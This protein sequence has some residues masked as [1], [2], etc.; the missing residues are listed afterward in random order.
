MLNPLLNFEGLSIASE[1]DHNLVPLIVF[2]YFALVVDKDL[3][4][5]FHLSHAIKAATSAERRCLSCGKIC[6]LFSRKCA[7]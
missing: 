4:C 7:G 1:R 3:S 5:A 2:V 6:F